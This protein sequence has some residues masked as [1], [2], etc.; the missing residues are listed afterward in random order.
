[1]KAFVCILCVIQYYVL[2]IAFCVLFSPTTFYTLGI[3]SSKST[4]SKPCYPVKCGWIC[5]TCKCVHKSKEGILA[6]PCLAETHTCVQSPLMCNNCFTLADDMST[7]K[8]QECRKVLDF[9]SLETPEVAHPTP[10][11][12]EKVVP[13]KVDTSSRV[14]SE[15]EGVTRELKR[16]RLLQELKAERERLADL[17]SKRRKSICSHLSKWET[18][19]TQDQTT[20]CLI[21]DIR[22]HFR[23][24]MYINGAVCQTGISGTDITDAMETLPLGPEESEHWAALEALAPTKYIL[25]I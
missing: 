19:K 25:N 12:E 13:G 8:S 9:T 3:G 6:H 5:T 4:G 16:L 21:L 23:H 22:K 10:P 24:K 1:M 14:K 11:T 17:I 20:Y 7:L 15:I 18:V 2:E